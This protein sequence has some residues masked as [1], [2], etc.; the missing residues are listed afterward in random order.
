MGTF[1]N[2]RM[3]ADVASSSPLLQ[4]LNPEQLAAVKQP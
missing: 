1:Y 3:F 4:N 2:G